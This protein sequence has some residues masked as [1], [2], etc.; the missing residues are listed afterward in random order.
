MIRYWKTHPKKPEPEEM[1]F[2]NPVYEVPE[3][4]KR[5]STRYLIAS[6]TTPEWFNPHPMPFSAGDPPF[7]FGVAHAQLHFGGP[8]NPWVADIVNPDEAV[9]AISGSSYTSLCDRASLEAF[10]D[11]SSSPL[12]KGEV[13]GRSFDENARVSIVRVRV[14]PTSLREALNHAARKSLMPVLKVISKMLDPKE[15]ILFEF[16]SMRADHPPGPIPYDSCP[17]KLQVC[18]LGRSVIG[19]GYAKGDYA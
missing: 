10:L 4:R 7:I 17:V 12:V 3:L 15:P 19:E 18:A 11:Y 6:A 5:A 13:E 16:S 9:N 14:D 2:T 1:S 8:E